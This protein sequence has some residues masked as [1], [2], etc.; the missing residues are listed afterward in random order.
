M[1]MQ[2]PPSDNRVISDG[3]EIHSIARS[4][5]YWARRAPSKV[6]AAAITNRHVEITRE[7]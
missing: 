2:S 5:S 6:T 1:T 3:A 7:I 4:R